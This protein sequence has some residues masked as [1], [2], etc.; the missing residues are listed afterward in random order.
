MND[1]KPYQSKTIWIN[2]ILAATAFIPSVH[3]FLS[4]HPE[5]IVFGFSGINMILRLVTKDKIQLT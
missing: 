2:F 4:S 1:K 5:L 3:E